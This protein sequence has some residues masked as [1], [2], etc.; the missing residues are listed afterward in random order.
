[1]IKIKIQKNKDLSLNIKSKK[2]QS[3]F[4]KAGEKK[5]S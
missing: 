1:M 4:F 3:I 2:D 5:R